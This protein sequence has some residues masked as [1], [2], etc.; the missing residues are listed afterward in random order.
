M[1]PSGSK[2]GRVR[3]RPRVKPIRVQNTI[4][5]ALQPM[6][7]HSACASPR[8]RARDTSPSTIRRPPPA[9][10]RSTYTSEMYAASANVTVPTARASSST[11][12]VEY[13]SSRCGAKRSCEQPTLEPPRELLLGHE[14]R[15]RRGARPPT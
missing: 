9:P 6:T 8:S 4:A 2:D 12:T 11:S 13:G 1:R 15:R 7:E 14:R 5:S 10:G 3:K